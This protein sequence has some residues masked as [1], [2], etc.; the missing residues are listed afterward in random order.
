MEVAVY[1]KIETVQPGN[2]SIIRCMQCIHELVLVEY[3]ELNV[4]MSR[5]GR[6]NSCIQESVWTSMLRRKSEVGNYAQYSY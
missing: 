5:K 3:L 2:A 1:V 6:K 4:V